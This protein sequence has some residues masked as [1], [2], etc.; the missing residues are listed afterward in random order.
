VKPR[1]KAGDAVRAEVYAQSKMT[2]L[3]VHVDDK[4]PRPQYFCLL[5]SGL[6]T[7][8]GEAMLEAA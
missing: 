7:V 8:M 2:V 6:C 4:W 1:F 3:A 5:P